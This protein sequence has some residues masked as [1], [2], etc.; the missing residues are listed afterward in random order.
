MNH[1]KLIPLCWLSTVLLAASL[2]GCAAV[3]VADAAVTVV[4]TGVK[5]TAK[6]V[7]AVADVVIPDGD[8]D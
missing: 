8:D 2:S 1:S 7:G 3:A 6:T 5:I 4:A